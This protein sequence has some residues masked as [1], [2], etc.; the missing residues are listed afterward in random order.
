MAQDQSVDV[1]D[2]PDQTAP[3][4]APIPDAARHRWSELAERILAAQFAYYVRD[5]PTISDAEYDGLMRELEALEGEHPGLRTPD[6]PTQNVGGTFSTDFAA[7]DHLERML[8]LDNVFSAAELRAWAERAERDAGGDEAHPVTFLCELKIDGLAINLLYERGRLVRAATRG[9]GRTGEDVT[10]NV[11]TI[12]GVPHVLAGAGVPELVEI[13]G[14]IFFPVEAFADLNASLVE[15]GKA[16]FANPRNA[17]AGSLRQKDPRVTRH[18]AA[19]AA[20]ARH[21]RP[22]RARRGAPVA[23]VR[24][25]ARRGA[26]PCRRRTGWCGSIDEVLRLRRDLPRAPARPDPRDRRRRREGRRRDAAAQARRHQP[27]AA[28][29]HRLQVPARRGQHEAPRHPGQRRAGPAG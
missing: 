12:E 18:P 21:R 3:A 14:E 25:D 10:L 29:G 13:R 5:A 1:Q 27:G 2:L 16:P 19:A 4:Q 8:S 9:D 7:A 22:A 26:C 6:S 23:G 17:A 15:A 28:V 11:R 24:P 20:R